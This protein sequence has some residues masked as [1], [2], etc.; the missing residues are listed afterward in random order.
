MELSKAERMMLGI[1][2]GDALGKEYENKKRKE[3][4]LDSVLDGYDK[5]TGVY[6][7][8]TQMS[9]AVAETMLSDFPFEAEV[10]AS[11]LV[12]AFRRDNRSGYSSDTK[13]MLKK[14]W[15]G[16]DFIN[17][18]SEKKKAGRM[19]DGSAMRAVPIGLFPD[20]EDVVR[21][22]T[23]NSEISHSHPYAVSAS[24]GIALAS[25]YFYYSKGPG[26]GV[27][28]Y[29]LL[30]MEQKY[31]EM[32]DYL[33]VVDELEE[34]NYNTILGKYAEFGPPYTNAKPV[35]G[36]VLFMVKKYYDDPI[37]AIKETISLGGDVDTT[38]SMVLGI[39]LAENPMTSIPSN[40]CKDLEN[41]RYGR[42]YL[43]ELG[44]KLEE[45][46]PDGE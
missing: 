39:I 36:T 41:G 20:T 26:N 25:H 46:Y 5:G 12:Y 4:R 10:L 42:D 11:N 2:I 19:S 40:L 16:K 6:T 9:I 15:C 38:L 3:I 35:L 43:L 27:I 44:R 31:T 28:E 7:D 37:R 14:S 29:I 18:I 21:N 8:D 17:S 45:K 30:H 23:I 33:K 32:L 24:I 34:F 22:A 13:S 1:A